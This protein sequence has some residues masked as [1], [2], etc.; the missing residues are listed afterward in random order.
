MER[1]LI[2]TDFSPAARNACSYG[3]QMA[4]MHQLPVFI[5]HVTPFPV[6]Y[7]EIPVVLDI[8][9]V[10]TTARQQ[11][12]QLQSEIVEEMK[13]QAPVET[14][15]R[16][17]DFLSELESRCLS[18][19]PSLVIMGSQGKSGMERF[20]FGSNTVK[21]MK[22]L[23][24]PLLCVSPAAR[25][26]G[27]K[28]IGFA[29]D[30]EHILDTVPVRSIKAIVKTFGAELHLLHV[31][32]GKNF[33][34]E[35]VFGS[36]LS[37]ELFWGVRPVL[38]LSDHENIYIGIMEQVTATGL[39]LLITIPHEHGFIDRLINRSQSKE[40]ILNSEVPVLILR[41]SFDR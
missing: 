18:Y 16:T 14:E 1:I 8:D 11:M 40:F 26:N 2:A 4:A 13:G 17:G 34:P 10:L 38:H 35:I 37:R 5:L 15:V 41:K 36:A 22:Q 9:D 20:F 19:Q 21:A 6:V 33:D 32:T 39:D 24:W 3:A 29:T 25:F 23:S 30:F 7:P 12:E 31:N 28:K 27:I